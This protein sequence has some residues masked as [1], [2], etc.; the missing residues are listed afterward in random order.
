MKKMKFIIIG[1]AL[2]ALAIPSVASAD[3]VRH[4]DNQQAAFTLKQP[5][6]Y[7]DGSHAGEFGDWQHDVTVKV[8]PCD[9]TFV[10]TAKVF[11]TDT[12]WGA[13]VLA[14]ENISGSFGADGTVSLT[15][16]RP[17]YN[18]VETLVGAKMDGTT[19]SHPTTTGAEQYELNM[20]VTKPVF[21]NIV[22]GV[23]Y[24][25][26]GDYVKAMGGGADAAHSCIGMPVNSSK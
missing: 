19:V 6:V 12:T 2:M 9:N 11:A 16:T 17:G 18:G 24:K 1:A 10:G 25:N 7:S 23:I 8:N 15:L 20:K 14:D 13:P 5:V 26:H 4:Q 3:V 21:S 22:G